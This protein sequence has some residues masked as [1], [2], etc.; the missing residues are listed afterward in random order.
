MDNRPRMQSASVRLHF[1][2]SLLRITAVMRF[3]R[4]DIGP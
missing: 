2:N 3:A 4:R 1:R